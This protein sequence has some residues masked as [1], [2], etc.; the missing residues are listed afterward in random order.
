MP[1]STVVLR[2]E[3]IIGFYGKVT[4]CRNAD[5]EVRRGEVVGLVGP[6][7]AGKTTLLRSL[8]GSIDTR[9]R[10]TLSGRDISRLSVDRRARLGL[11]YVPDTRGLFPSMSVRENLL[12]GARLAPRAIRRQSIDD[13]VDRFPFLKQRM[14]TI[15]GQLS[16]GEQQMLA[17]AKALVGA[18]EVLLLDEPSQGL[19]PIILDT[20]A[21]AIGTLRGRNF[22]IVLA[23]Q[24]GRFASRLIDRSLLMVSG[25]IDSLR[26]VTDLAD[27]S[28][29]FRAFT[30]EPTSSRTKPGS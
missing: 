4:G 26:Q 7:G 28:A 21:R 22:G 15:A 10:V 8:A 23:E 2:A 17:I 13:E 29:L 27:S 19:A 30:T 20:L 5:L 18:P 24:N 1:D 16:G 14:A 12:I 25:E 3:G 6:N 11:R 9:G